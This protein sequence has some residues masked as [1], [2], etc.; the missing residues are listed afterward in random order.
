MCDDESAI[1]VNSHESALSDFDKLSLLLKI[2]TF[3]V[4]SFMASMFTRAFSS[5][6]PAP[7]ELV[8][9]FSS[10]GNLKHAPKLTGKTLTHMLGKIPSWTYHEPKS[11]DANLNSQEI[12][13]SSNQEIVRP[14]IHSNPVTL[15]RLDSSRPFISKRYLFPSFDSA[16]LF[17]I[18]CA[19]YH[20]S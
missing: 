3:F 16:F 9:L 7:P 20:D 4:I 2:T 14:S 10:L 12:A 11:N 19:K 6:L 17:M 18:R 8:N 15:L 5:R 1:S 13:N